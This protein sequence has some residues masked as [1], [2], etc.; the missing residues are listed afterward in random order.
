[1]EYSVLI[2]G[3]G[4]QGVLSIGKMLCYG[5]DGNGKRAT[6][7]PTYGGEQRGGTANCTVIISDEEIASPVMRQADIVIV[8]NEPS[9]MKF[10]D[11]VKPGGTLLIN[12]S[13]VASRPQRDDITAVEVPA[14]E[15]AAAVNNPKASNMVILG[16]FL[17]VTNFITPEQMEE[18]IRQQ[19]A[20]K[21]Q[22]MDANLEAFRRGFTIGQEESDGRAES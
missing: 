8:M 16:A 2:A 3:F 15:I 6:F 12:S 19:M 18:T 13:N 1:M 9:F 14:D 17:K 7:F 21:P 4:G 20:G 10:V 22:Y 11:R 5:A